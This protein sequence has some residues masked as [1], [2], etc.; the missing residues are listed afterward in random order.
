MESDT[1][2]YWLTK[3]VVV[4][5]YSTM[6][7]HIGD[8]FMK[9]EIESSHTKVNTI[10]IVFTFVKDDNRMHYIHLKETLPCKLILIIH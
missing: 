10:I 1:I 4:Q 2:W 8:K 9:L 3:T 6:Y 7:K 5:E